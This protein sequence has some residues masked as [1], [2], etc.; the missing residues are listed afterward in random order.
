MSPYIISPMGINRNNK[1]NNANHKEAKNGHISD[2]TERIPGKN[3]IY[4]N[5]I[6][7]NRNELVR[8]LL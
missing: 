4:S 3:I 8:R 6:M 5:N 1:K 2:F 7:R